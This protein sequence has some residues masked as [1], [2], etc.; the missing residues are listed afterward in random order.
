MKLK[1]LLVPSTMAL[2]LAACGNQA[3]T[4]KTVDSASVE[5]KVEKVVKAIAKPELGTFG[6]AMSDMDTAVKPGD[7]FF[8][9]VNGTWLANTE[10]PAD[11]SNFGSFGMLGDR[12][13]DNVKKI[14]FCIV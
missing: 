6:I 13:D 4:E 3:A 9:Y 12:S 7:N 10:I 8:E 1:H 5:T 14:I 2:I 11:K